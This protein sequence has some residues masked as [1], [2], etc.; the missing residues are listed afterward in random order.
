MYLI[1]GEEFNLA[2]PKQL[3]AILFEK[4]QLPILKKTPTKQPATSEEVLSILSKDFEIAA[5]LLSYRSLAKLKSTYIDTLP[6]DINP[7][8]G[9]VHCSYNQAVTTTGRLSSTDPNLQNIPIKSA[10]GR[11][12]RKAFI[13]PEGRILLAA[14]YSQIE[15]RIMAH[16]SGDS[17]LC[18]AF[19]NKLD[20]HSATAAEVLGLE[21]GLVTSEQRRRAKAVNFGLIYGMSAFGLAKQLDISRSEAQ[22]YIDKYFARYAGVKNYMETVRLQALEV[23]YVTT[24]FGRKLYLQGIKDR[25]AMVRKAAERA[26][27]NAPLQG[28]AADIMKVAMIQVVAALSSSNIDAKLLL[29]VHDELVFEVAKNDLAELSTIVKEAMECS[30][31]VKVPLEVVCGSGINWDDAH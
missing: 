7:A 30:A 18:D 24:I 16:F 27:I 5:K 12:I 25:N 13:A 2:S 8:S 28:S 11:L 20:I 17:V 22:E 10:E 21:V 26:A 6:Q 4:L 15:L 19:A 31:T 14:D 23:G 29:Q 3:R 1:A 9:R